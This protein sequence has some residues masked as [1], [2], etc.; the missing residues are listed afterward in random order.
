MNDF[1]IHWFVAT[2]NGMAAGVGVALWK[3]TTRDGRWQ[4]KVLHGGLIALNVFCVI[5]LTWVRQQ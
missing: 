3:W 4:S 5:I 1:L 2:V